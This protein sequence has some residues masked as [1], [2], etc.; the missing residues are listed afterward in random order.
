MSENQEPMTTNLKPELIESF[1]KQRMNEYDCGHDWW[2]IMRVRQLARYINEQE[3]MADNVILDI[4]ACLHDMADS[5]FADA[6][7]EQF[8]AEISAFLQETGMSDISEQLI[9]V[10]K[11]V[12]FS[13]RNKSGELNDPVL[14]ILQDADMLDAMGAIGIARAFSYGGFRKRAIFNPEDD[15]GKSLSTIA[16]F[17]DKLLKLKD[18]MNTST[19]RALADERHLFLEKYLEEFYREWNF[20]IPL[21]PPDN[22]C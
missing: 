11:N 14:L 8:Y 15:Q 22:K 17:H 16:H 7:T 18:M 12:S 3:K 10:I 19:G 20:A 4:A 6:K 2:H 9:R 13:N 5:K 21:F 1:V